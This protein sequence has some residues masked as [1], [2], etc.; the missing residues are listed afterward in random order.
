MS[1]PIEHVET[2][3]TADIARFHDDPY[4]FTMY[5]WPWGVSGGELEKFQGPRAWQAKILKDIG[6]R[7]K[8]G[9]AQDNAVRSAIQQAVASGHG[10]GKSALISMIMYWAMS[11]RA[12]TRG[13]TTAN[14]ERQLQGKTW[15]EL[16]KWHRLAINKNW[17]TYSATALASSDPQYERTWRIDAVPWSEHNSESFA[18]LHN[19]GNR[20]LVIFDEASAI[21]DRIWEVTEGALS[22]SDAEIIWLAFGNPTRLTGR[23]RE[24]F[25][26]L[27][28]RWTHVQ[29]DSRE[30]EG[31]NKDQ[32]QRWVEDY[33]EDSDFVRVRVRGVFPRASTTQFISSEHVEQACRRTPNPTSAD[34]VIMGVDVARFGADRSVIYIRHGSDAQ[35]TPPIVLRGIDT[36]TLV[37]RISEILAKRPI[38]M[39]FVDETGVGGGVVDRLRQ[40][41]NR[42]IG[43]N[44]G[45]KSDSPGTGE[46]VAN[47]GTECWAKMR[48][49]LSEW[50]TIPN[51]AELKTDLE[52]REYGYNVRN[53]LMLES[54]DDMKK[55]GLASCD[56]A[57]AL[58][59][60]FAY[61]VAPQRRWIDP[62]LRKH[63]GRCFTDDDK[64]QRTYGNGIGQCVTDSDSSDRYS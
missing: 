33:G 58:A 13:V 31:T 52:G 32:I 6:A 8:A 11:T 15:P 55:R 39:I 49:W 56:L 7:L 36:M 48:L 4:G 54:K 40:L 46:L 57:D 47:K 27:G 3:I 60:T 26:S 63:A 61:P 59:L 16:A 10:I 23:F 20:I 37:G 17:F 51:D 30:V 28:H 9:A 25:G 64:I 22:D 2:D 41:G 45:A 62:E 29:I 21:S 42:V 1:A 43:V 18:G 44:N 24:C 19:Q 5:C 53:E 38:D 14:T 34:P 35:S 50:G 12:N